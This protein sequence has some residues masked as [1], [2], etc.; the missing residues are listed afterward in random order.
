[1][2]TKEEEKKISDCEIKQDIDLI[3]PDKETLDRG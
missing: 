2:K 1:M 3:N